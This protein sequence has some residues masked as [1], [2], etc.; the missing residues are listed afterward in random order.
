MSDD[1]PVSS[2]AAEDGPAE[3]QGRYGFYGRLTS[4]FPSQVIVDVTEVCNLACVHCAHPSFKA[5]EHYKARYLEPELNTKLVDE[6][7]ERAKGRGYIRY[8]SEGEPLLHKRAFE[9]IA[10]AVERS[11][12][13]VTLT[14]NGTLLDDARVDALLATRVA[15]VDISIDA[16]KPETYAAIR[17]K[18]DLE[19]TQRNVQRLLRRIEESSAATKVVVSF[20]EQPNNAD[21]VESFERF[22]RGEGAHEVVVRR[23]HSNSGALVDIARNIRREHAKQRR[24]P[25]LYPW[26]RVVLNP[27][28]FLAFCPADWTHGSS[29]IDYRETTIAETWQGPLYQSLREA[30]LTNSYAGHKFCGQCPDWRQTRWPDEGRSYADLVGELEEAAP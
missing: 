28:G 22:W 29:L 17:V 4:D 2:P 18:G 14:T 27:R 3:A 25:C 8:T 20:I 5:S 19:V 1:R 7:A 26:E 21:E 15:M 23:L 30:H 6:V 9:M 12:V 10:D 11:G 13:T 24:R 16:F